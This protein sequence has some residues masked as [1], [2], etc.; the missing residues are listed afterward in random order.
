MN[1]FTYS[2]NN[3]Y[4]STSS[5][6]LKC[7]NNILVGSLRFYSTT[8]Y[9][10]IK[11]AGNN[12][13][14]NS[15]SN[16]RDGVSERR[17]YLLGLSDDQLADRLIEMRKSLEKSKEHLDEIEKISKFLNIPLADVVSSPFNLRSSILAMNAGVSF[18]HHELRKVITPMD[19]YERLK[20]KEQLERQSKSPTRSRGMT[21]STEQELAVKAEQDERTCQE[22]MKTAPQWVMGE[23]EMPKYSSFHQEDQL[24]T[25]NPAHVSKWTAHEMI[26]RWCRFYWCSDQT[27]YQMYLG[28]KLNELLPVIHWHALELLDWSDDAN[29]KDVAKRIKG[30]IS[31]FN[32]ELE[33]LEQEIFKGLNSLD[34]HG[35]EADDLMHHP[36]AVL[37]W[38]QLNS[39]TDTMLYVKSHHS[40]LQSEPF[41]TVL[42]ALSKINGNQQQYFIDTIRGYRAYIEKCFDQLLFDTLELD[43]KLSLQNR[44]NR[45]KVD[46]LMREANR[47]FQVYYQYGM[48]GDKSAASDLSRL[49]H[50]CRSLQKKPTKEFMLEAKNYL[51]P[52]MLANGFNINQDPKAEL[53]SSKQVHEGLISCIP[54]TATMIEYCIER[55]LLM[56]P[57]IQSMDELILHFSNS[58]FFYQRKSISNRFNQFLNSLTDTLPII[59]KHLID[60]ENLIVQ[61]TKDSMDYWI[62]ELSV[63]IDEELDSDEMAL[64]TFIPSR[65]YRIIEINHSLLSQLHKTFSE[66]IDAKIQELEV[67]Y[68]NKKI[69]EREIQKLHDGLEKL[70]SQSFNQ[71]IYDHPTIY[72]VG[73]FDGQFY[74]LDMLF[75]WKKIWNFLKSNENGLKY[76]DLKSHS[77]KLFEESGKKFNEKEF[78]ST[79]LELNQY[80]AVGMFPEIE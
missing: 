69:I 66:D 35:V 40:R 29:V 3:Y 74:S 70:V 23:L 68:N 49:E 63:S 5:S 37:D 41:V 11:L 8:H 12:N 80:G 22:L 38:S 48:S 44:D 14:N 9:H 58:T 64:F 61:Q 45:L 77:I 31:Y 18:S 51:N 46:L 19:D 52:S 79:L 72:L 17:N 42:E 71:E 30:A 50:L 7:Y 56:L 60:F 59:F 65:S 73:L 57:N 47:Q 43:T 34:K 28:A 21:A 67:S 76:N 6:S 62:E 36:T 32:G 16:N 2:L 54:A 20:R 39:V 53:L 13:N 10:G 24:A 75:E 33:L 26:H 1:R 4:K 15:S 55:K 78:I 25:Y 27:K